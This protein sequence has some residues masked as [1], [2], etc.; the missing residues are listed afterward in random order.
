MDYKTILVQC[1]ENPRRSERFALG[2]RLAERFGAHLTAL[3]AMRAAFLPFYPLA[4][5]DTTWLRVEEQTRKTAASEAQSAFETQAMRFPKVAIDFRVVGRGELTDVGSRARTADLVLAGQPESDDAVARILAGD[6]LLTAGRPIL[7]VPYAGHF[8]DVGRRVLIAWNDSREAARAVADALPILRRAESVDLV[9]F[10][11]AAATL[12]A[13]A[14]E[15]VVRQ[16]GRHGVKVTVDR[17]RATDMKVGDL[18][19]ANAD[20]RGSDLIVM[21]GYG[22]S[23]IRERVLGGATRALL[24]V[25]TVPVLMSH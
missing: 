3:F 13:E 8:P 20:D 10:E 19:L 18:I 22:H 7:F 21:G 11:T 4:E 16:L 9:T 14:G 2:L 25:M 15:D 6:L 5:A 23:R 17:D 24:D 1:D 12:P